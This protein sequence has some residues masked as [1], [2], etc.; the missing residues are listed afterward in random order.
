VESRVSHDDLMRY[1]DGEV[2]PE[3]RE[4]ID[5]T[6]Q[7]STELQRELAVFQA[8]KNDLRDLSFAPQA[9]TGSVWDQVNRRLARP[10]G[11]VFLVAGVAAWMVY[12]GFLFFTSAADPI[13]KM[14]TSAVGI[15]VLLLL[16]TVI[17]ERYQDWLTD[18]YRD[19]HR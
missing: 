6:L 10:L 7:R 17:W 14:A 19:V 16:A 13:E 9:V 1:L 18:P 2:S 4:Q 5:E 8:M 15:G 11:W 3:E 12:G